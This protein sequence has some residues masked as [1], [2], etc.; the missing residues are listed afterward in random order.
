MKLAGPPEKY[1]RRDQADTRAVIEREDARNRKKGQDLELAGERLILT[2][3]DGSKF[4]L[5]V[6]DLSLI[7]I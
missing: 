1:D 4:I 6:S 2:S 3:P 5:T 7:H